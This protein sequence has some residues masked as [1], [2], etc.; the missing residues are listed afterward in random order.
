MLVVSPLL[1]RSGEGAVASQRAVGGRSGDGVLGT[2]HQ[3]GVLRD[4]AHGL[5][6]GQGGV[7]ASSWTNTQQYY[8]NKI[9]SVVINAHESDLDCRIHVL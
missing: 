9:K 1:A 5:G 4:V 6:A 3:G 2:G 8:Y 7:V